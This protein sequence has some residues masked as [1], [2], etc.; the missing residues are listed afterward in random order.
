MN[1]I[2]RG[3]YLILPDVHAVHAGLALEMT[4]TEPGE[5]AEQTPELKSKNVPLG[6]DV[7]AP[8][9]TLQQTRRQTRSE[10]RCIR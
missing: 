3:G 8:P 2:L 1:T 6:H 7:Q 4:R 5:H 10:G 9:A